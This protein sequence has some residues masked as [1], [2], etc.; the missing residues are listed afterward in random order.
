MVAARLA[1]APVALVLLALLAAPAPARAASAAR[2]PGPWATVN[3]CDT[4]AHPDA[5]GVRA[6]MPGTGSARDTLTMR[7]RLQYL[8]R[9]D[10][11]WLEVGRGGDSGVIAA[12]DGHA[13][14]RGA[15]WTFTVAPPPEGRPP[16][17]LRG[18]VT[19]AWRRDGVLVRRARR[20]TQGGR[21]DTPGADPP[22][23]TAATCAVR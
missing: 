21:P 9:A 17:I 22:G 6:S 5:I 2:P 16:Y 23:Y 4:A 19:F 15:G 20:V 10:G 3:L 18:V 7:I 8:R 14:A 11:R 12:G 1:A 13:R